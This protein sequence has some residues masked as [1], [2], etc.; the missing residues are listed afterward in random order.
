MKVSFSSGVTNGD[1]Y[2]ITRS[3]NHI[4]GAVTIDEFVA[5]NVD[6][7]SRYSGVVTG[8]PSAGA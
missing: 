4:S 1:F 7:L 8:V 2:G 3:N 5:R 6:E